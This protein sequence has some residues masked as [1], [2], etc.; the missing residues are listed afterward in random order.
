MSG[1]A[2]PHGTSP[3]PPGAAPPGPPRDITPPRLLVTLGGAGVL[4]GLLIVVAY[5]STQP[6]I[7]AH[8][9]EVLRAAIHEVLKAPDRYDTLY[10]YDG[11][12]RRRLP[13]GVGPQGLETVYHGYRG[14]TP[15][16]FAMAAGQP[17]F[18]DIVRLIFGYDP[19]TRTILG[20]KVLESKETPGL[21]DKIERDTAFV[22]QFD[23]VAP[24]LSGVKRRGGSR[25]AGE[26]DMITGA[27]ISSRTVIGIINATLE[28]L[29]PA[30]ERYDRE[31][32]R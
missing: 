17:G 4:A 29:G 3:V 26:I 11:A 28:R 31:A 24:P 18:Q 13:D 2:H 22:R 8:K 10:V 5:Q 20:M 9:A 14:T 32:P 15:A 23:G 19:A 16:G 12:L 1:D 30:L 27:T 6:A 25:A 21:G 7:Q